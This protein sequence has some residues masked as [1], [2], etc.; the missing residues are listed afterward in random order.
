MT[1][2]TINKQFSSLLKEKVKEFL[3][4]NMNVIN[5]LLNNDF[6]VAHYG[7]DYC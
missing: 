2:E 4:A 7:K 6:K 3:D 5:Y 1:F